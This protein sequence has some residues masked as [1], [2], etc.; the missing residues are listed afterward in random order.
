MADLYPPSYSQRP[1]QQYQQNMAYPPPQ[2]VANQHSGSS[3]NSSDDSGDQQ[4]PQQ[5]PSPTKSNSEPPKTETKPQATFLT[6]L[7]ALLERPENH[8]MIRWDPAGEHIIVE[9]PEQLALHVLPSI[10]RQSRFASF[11]RQLNIYGFMRKVNLRNVDPAIDD[12]D[13]STWS[14]PT[15]NRHSPPEVVANFKRRVPPRLPKPRKRD[16]QEAPTIPPPRTSIGMGVPLS[17]PP[18]CESPV[19]QDGWSTR[20][21]RTGFLCTGLLQ[22]PE[23]GKRLE[24]QLPALGS[25]TSDRSLRFVSPFSCQHVYQ[26]SPYPASYSLCR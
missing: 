12:P 11:S 14:H 18:G 21:S 4:Q 24:H 16:T 26:L 3:S 19:P 8:H 13:A 7:Y 15:L 22:S 17:V 6:K 5:P 10:Y 20:G 23:P 2:L 25:P 1:S 9:R